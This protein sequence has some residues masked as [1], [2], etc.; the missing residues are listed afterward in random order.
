MCTTIGQELNALYQV[1][2]GLPDEMRHLL[3]QLGALP[4]EE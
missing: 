4:E 3:T 2:Q 1:P